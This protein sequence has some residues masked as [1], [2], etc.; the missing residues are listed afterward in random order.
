MLAALVVVSGV[1]GAATII[2]CPNDPRD[3]GG[4]TCWGTEA[5]DVLIGTDGGTKSTPVS[6]RTSSRPGPDHIS[7]GDSDY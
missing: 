6:A 2:Q 3:I 5:D 4:G 7:S 1:A